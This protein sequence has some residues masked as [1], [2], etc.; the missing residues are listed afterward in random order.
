VGKRPLFVRLPLWVHYALAWCWERTMRVPLV[1]AAQVRI[2]SEGIVEPL[3]FVDDLP[4]HL[5]PRLRFTD[6]HIRRGLPK[7]GRF[8]LADCRC[9]TV[10]F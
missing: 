7:A 10:S 4:P 9:N 8:G 5:A 6:E 3:P 2:L 1:S